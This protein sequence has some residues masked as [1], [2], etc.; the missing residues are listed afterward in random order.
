[1]TSFYVTTHKSDIIIASLCTLV[2]L[3]ITHHAI[4]YTLFFCLQ[5]VDN[6]ARYL[7]HQNHEIYEQRGITFGDPM[8]RGLR[9]VSF[10]HRILPS[11]FPT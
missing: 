7:Q 11:P 4:K 2:N 9:C 3:H 1:M 6:V 10:L 5:T 8:D